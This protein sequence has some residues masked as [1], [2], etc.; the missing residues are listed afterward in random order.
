MTESSSS[1]AEKA[2][3]L[4]DDALVWDAHSCLPLRAGV[5]C[6]DLARHR[7]AGIDYVS[8]NIGMDFNPVAQIARVVATFRAY[9]AA[10]PD[11]YLLAGTVA[12]VHRA[13]ATGRLA[14]SFD[15]EGSD[16]LEGDLDMLLFYRDFGVRQMHLAYNRDNAVGG[17]CHG[18]DIGL[19]PFG[20]KVVAEINRLGIL[21]DCSHTGYR[22]SMEVM[23]ISAKP[24]IFS[25]ANPRALRDHPRNIRDDQIDACAKRGGVVGINGIGIFLGDDDNRTETVLRHIDYVAGRVGPE[26]VGIGLDFVFRRGLDEYPPGFE[27]SLWWPPQHSYVGRSNFVEPERM[28]AIAEGL[29]QLGYAESAIRGVLGEN[30]LRVAE[31]TWP[32]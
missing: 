18:A 1:P 14:V 5:D 30:F 28:T 4:Y 32:K 17:G 8:I 19:T 20:R 31:A 2:R 6:R 23:E 27:A 16:M 25:H 3:R 13:K 12:D 10:R 9:I 22:T 26:H 24:V 15:L 29:V 11:E 7:A 21:M